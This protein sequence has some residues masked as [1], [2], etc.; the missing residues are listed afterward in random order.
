[1]IFLF[2]TV[3]FGHFQGVQKWNTGLKRVNLQVWKPSL[4]ATAIPGNYDSVWLGH[5]SDL[6]SHTAQVAHIFEVLQLILMQKF[7][8]KFILFEPALSQR[9]SERNISDSLHEFLNS[10]FYFSIVSKIHFKVL[11]D[12]QLFITSKEGGNFIG[13]QSLCK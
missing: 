2:T 3:F 1:M 13:E 7:F 9:I 12:G 10:S 11:P 8:I 6:G 4:S 5:E